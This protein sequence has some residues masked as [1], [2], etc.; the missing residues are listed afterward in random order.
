[1]N[2]VQREHVEQI[3]KILGFS[4]IL[5]YNYADEDNEAKFVF[6]SPYNPAETGR[7]LQELLDKM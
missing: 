4:P 7:I 5:I 6:A 1:M 3:D 2:V